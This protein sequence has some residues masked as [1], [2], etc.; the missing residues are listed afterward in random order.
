MVVKKLFLRHLA[1][2]GSKETYPLKFDI[3]AFTNLSR[4]HLD[5]HKTLENYKLSKSILFKNHIKRIHW[6]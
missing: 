3:I 4:D 6:R 2:I 5:Y 1:L